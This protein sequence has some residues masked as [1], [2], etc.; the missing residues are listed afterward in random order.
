MRL[1]LTIYPAQDHLTGTSYTMSTVL[2]VC[3]GSRV[4][5]LYVLAVCIL[6][7]LAVCRV[8]RVVVIHRTYRFVPPLFWNLGSW[9]RGYLN[10]T[11]VTRPAV[12]LQDLHWLGNT[13]PYPVSV[14]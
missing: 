12:T 1:T 2:A 4:Y 9:S 5:L 13:I 6:A 11:P 14:K 3:R 7:V 10:A 8:T